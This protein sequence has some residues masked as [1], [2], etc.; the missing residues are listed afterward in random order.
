MARDKELLEVDP[1]QY[2]EMLDDMD[3]WRHAL[4]LY[5]EVEADVDE[6]APDP[7]CHECGSYNVVD[8]TEPDELGCWEI[9]CRDCG[10]TSVVGG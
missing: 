5:E 3:R 4:E 8:T 1:E 9:H 2:R 10:A 6:Q 7:F